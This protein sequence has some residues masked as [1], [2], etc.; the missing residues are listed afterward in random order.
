[1]YCLTP[2]S[3]PIFR[4]DFYPSFPQHFPMLTRLHNP[5]TASR[6]LSAKSDFLSTRSE[7]RSQRSGVFSEADLEAAHGPL[8]AIVKKTA[9]QQIPSAD[10]A[11]QRLH[12]I[13][14]NW[15]KI[16]EGLSPYLKPHAALLKDLQSAGVP[17]HP[18]AYDISPELM[19]TAFLY[20]ADIRDRYTVLHFARDCGVLEHYADEVLATAFV[21]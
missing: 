1:M 16:W 13:Q 6:S 20:A 11:Q 17:C 19:R 15:T 9:I 5:E 10:A 4:L 7:V 2:F 18:S 8:W 14:E 3:D 12:S 21:R